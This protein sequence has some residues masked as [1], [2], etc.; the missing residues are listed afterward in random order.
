MGLKDKAAL[1]KRWAGIATGKNRVAVRQDVGKYYKLDEIAGYYND[2]TGKVDSNTLLDDNGIPI[3]EI[4]GGKKVYFPISIFQYALGLWD[5]SIGDGKNKEYQAHFLKLCDWIYEHQRSD[6]SWD[7]FSP[8][9]YKTQ[10]V[11]AMGQGEAVSVLIR[12]YQ[13]TDEEKWL[14]SAGKAAGFMFVPVNEGG[15]LRRDGENVYLEEYPGGNGEKL[16]VLN[17]WIFSVFGLYDYLIIKKDDEKVMKLFESTV[18]TMVS[19]LNKYDNG[20]WSCYDQTGRIASP[21]YHQLH[22]ALLKVMSEITS[23]DIFLEYFNRWSKYSD[24]SL[25]RIRAV[26][27]KVVQKLGDNPE[28]IIIR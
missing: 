22:I 24:S 21:A 7:C 19:C 2:L 28:G 6:G 4:A 23:E 8:I 16:S 3:N 14:E 5:L 10:T 27:K 15:V 9:G 17:G 25:C 12:A 1:L 20:Y 26:L 18:K 11:S 13:L